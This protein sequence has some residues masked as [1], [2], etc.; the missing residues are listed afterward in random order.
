MEMV[1]DECAEQEFMA[2]IRVLEQHRPEPACQEPIILENWH[3]VE[4]QI[5]QLREQ[6]HAGWD[7]ARRRKRLQVRLEDAVAKATKAAAR[8]EECEKALAEATMAYTAAIS[9]A[10]ARGQERE[11]LR[12]ELEEHDR[13][14]PASVAR[15]AGDSCMHGD[16]SP[17]P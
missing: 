7:P 5:N 9:A 16:A 2:R 10:Q 13:Q 11:A 6:I 3:W 8:K 4:E 17:M 1:L 15:A 14:S 12:Q